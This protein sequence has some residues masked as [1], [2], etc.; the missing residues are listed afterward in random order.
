MLE[1][2]GIK[3]THLHFGKHFLQ[4]LYG[5]SRGDPNR[6]VFVEGGGCEILK[7][8]EVAA[9]EVAVQYPPNPS[10]IY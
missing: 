10:S 6:A 8:L 7:E 4:Q 9:D 1:L 2:A 5:V 3:A